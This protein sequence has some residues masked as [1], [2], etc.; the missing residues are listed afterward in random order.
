MQ[1][2]AT[3]KWSK[4]EKR[5]KMLVALRRPAGGPPASTPEQRELR[6]PARR[7]FR[8]NPKI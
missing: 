5:W 6:G 4:V 8:K 1:L 3:G 7:R 2:M